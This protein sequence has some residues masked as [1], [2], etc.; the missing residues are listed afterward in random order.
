M[1]MEK[2]KKHWSDNPYR[3]IIE[4]CEVRAMRGIPVVDT[5]KDLAKGVVGYREGKATSRIEE[6]LGFVIK[7][8]KGQYK[9]KNYLVQGTIINE[10]K[11]E[12]K[13]EK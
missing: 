6:A 1:K 10:M 13:D 8:F 12:L 5:L 7:N 3:T 11:K 4:I 2:F 9:L